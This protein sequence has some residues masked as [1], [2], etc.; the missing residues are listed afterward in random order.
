[1]SQL[2]TTNW[3]GLLATIL[4]SGGS[5]LGVKYVFDLFLLRRQRNASIEQINIDADTRR[6]QM[7]DSIIKQFADRV[8]QLE[9]NDK[10]KDNIIQ[11]QNRR[12]A[13]LERL[14]LVN[15]LELPPEEARA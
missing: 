4:L 7:A 8:K 6:V 9:E 5:G 14:L 10:R 15:G 1:M 3:I 11:Y 13:R 2:P 12:I